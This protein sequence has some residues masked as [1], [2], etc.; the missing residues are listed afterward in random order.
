[1]RR[2]RACPHRMAAVT[3]VLFLVLAAR[4]WPPA[5]AI[6]RSTANLSRVGDL[7]AAPEAECDISQAAWVGTSGYG[8]V[9]IDEAGW[10]AFAGEG[11]G[12]LSG[13]VTDIAIG[14]DGRVWV[15]Q[16]GGL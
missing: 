8:L 11:S 13:I 14:P 4:G 3:A 9:C 6:D 1:M 10:R 2:W 7:S 12:L 16:P 5:A 15:A